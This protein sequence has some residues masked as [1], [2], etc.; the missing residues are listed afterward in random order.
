MSETTARGRVRVEPSQ[1]RVRTYLAG[2]L[3][4]DTIQP[5]LVWEIPYYPAYYIRAADVRAKLV[6]TGKTEH[7]PSRGEAE[8]LDVVT[9]RGTAPGAA[10]R[11]P[12]SPI[13]ELRDAVRLDFAAMDEWLEEDEPIYV[14]PRSPYAR[15]DILASSRHVRVEI[16]GVTVA[17]SRSP[18]ILYETGLPPR[19]YL[20][21][22]DVRMDLLVPS[23]T[24][25]H[26]PYKGTAGYWSV[27]VNGERYDDYV[28]I[29]RSPL[30]ESQKIAGLACFYNEKV[31][32]Y[33]DGVAQGRPRTP[34]S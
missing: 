14:H 17:E 26:C 3:V 1:K 29:Y 23:D 4:A 6:A 25:T 5:L 24:Q 15:V 2:D 33:V 20:P 27:E 18:R 28:W 11:Y 19:Y 30:P 22:P 12:E 34:F 10:R 9:E 16:D 31:D 32:L 8:I 7:S 13:E 21:L